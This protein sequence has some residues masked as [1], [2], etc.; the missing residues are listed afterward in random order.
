MPLSLVPCLFNDRQRQRN[1]VRTEIGRVGTKDQ[2]GFFLYLPL[3]GLAK[4]ETEEEC[5][6]AFS[7]RETEE[8]SLC[9]NAALWAM[10]P[11][12]RLMSDRRDRDRKL[13]SE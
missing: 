8:T 2:S 13:S 3:P 10:E 4:T 12:R 9:D 7:P 11:G 5:H 1:P 6:V